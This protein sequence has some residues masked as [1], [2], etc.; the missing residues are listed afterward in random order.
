VDL[1]HPD[2]RINLHLTP[3]EAVVSLDLSGS[4]LHRRGYRLEGGE[5]PL[6]EN[7]AAAILLR[8]GWPRVA[9][10]GG[11]LLDPMCGSGT[12]LIEGALMAA[13]IAPGLLRD[14]YGFLGWN[15]HEPQAWAEFLKEAAERRESG[16]T[17]L[18]ALFGFDLDQRAVGTARGNV[19][20]AGLAGRI[21]LERR[22]LAA[23]TAPDRAATPPASPPGLVVTNPPYGK[24][25][26]EVAELVGVYETLGERLKASFS[27]WETAIFTGNPDLGAHLG[28]RAHRINVFFNGPIEC[29]LL[30]FHIGRVEASAG[31]RR[32]GAGEPEPGAE[33]RGAAGEDGGGAEGDTGA[34]GGVVE[35]LRVP[36][37]SRNDAVLGTGA[38]MFE[39]RLRKNLKHLR[40]W[41]IREDVHCYRLYD[42]DLP[43]YAVAVDLYEDW[44]RCGPAA[45]S[46]RSWPSYRRFSRSLRSG[47]CSKSAGHNAEPSSIKSCE[48]GVRSCRRGRGASASW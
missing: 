7:L 4:G 5:A 20:R 39:N 29:R 22:D 36:S 35:A 18:P 42:A 24:R 37:L 8:A 19:R 11:T 47:W 48:T 21:V 44:A 40:R 31:R 32:L 46:R 3:T 10:A 6:K 41:A 17:R 2:V 25:L 13:D 12:L 43:E 30:Q 14:Y 15:G 38:S 16:L 28:L 26:G 23:L 33:G 45:G 34:E 27:G 9:A 1:T